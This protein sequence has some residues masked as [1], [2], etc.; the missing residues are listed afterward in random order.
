M[1]VL[2]TLIVT[3]ICIFLAIY[4][5]ISYAADPVPI[6]EGE[7]APFDGVIITTVEAAIL[8]ASLEQ[9]TERCQ[10]NINLAVSTAVAAKQL[11]LDT[12]NSNFAIRTDLYNAQ[13]TG[14]RDY[15]IYL[16][17]RLTR[18]RLAPEWMLVIGIV[19]G[20]GITIGAGIA[21]NQAAIQ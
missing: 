14:Y 7:V 20:V 6:K 12:C 2:S 11:E 13:L 15:S 21:M 17:E 9:Q 19:T 8:L 3:W 5:V 16:E 4:P 1:K 10:A 18:P